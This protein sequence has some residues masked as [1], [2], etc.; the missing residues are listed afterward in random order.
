MREREKV[1]ACRPPLL[2][3]E[4]HQPQTPPVV[5]GLRWRREPAGLWWRCPDVLQL[6]GREDSE[7]KQPFIP[8]PSE[9]FS[10]SH[11]NV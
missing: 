1:C 10:E 3:V 4:K 5:P 7:T 9:V 8:C 11:P 2:P 6:A